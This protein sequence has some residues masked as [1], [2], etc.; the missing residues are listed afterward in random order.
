VSPILYGDQGL[1]EILAFCTIAKQKRWSVDRYCGYHAHFNVSNESWDSLKSIAY[2]YRLTYEMWCC[3]VPE[4]R[5]SNPYCGAPD[6][7]LEDVGRINNASDWEYFVGARDRFEFVNWRAYLV[8]GSFEVRS[9]E[10][11][12]NGP[13]VCNWI[14]LHA[15]FIDCVSAM[16]IDE[17]D[18]R[19][20]GTVETQFAAI[21]EFIGE[22][23]FEIYAGLSD[24]YGHPLVPQE[25]VALHP[26]F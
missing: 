21:K 10:G 15:R 16:S 18:D 26:P 24:E 4:R 11:T 8:H 14:K 7:A 23:L 9:H 20:S 22:E 2:A 25:L 1:M 13:V 6:Y 19:F 12:L 5:A 3:L 17:I